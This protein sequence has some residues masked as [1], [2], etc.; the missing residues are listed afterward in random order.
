MEWSK[1]KAIFDKYKLVIIN[2]GVLIVLLIIICWYMFYNTNNIDSTNNRNIGIDDSTEIINKQNKMETKSGKTSALKNENKVSDIFVDIKGA[3][4]H[5]NI[6]KMKNIDRVKQLVDKAVLLPDADLSK[7]NLAERL[8]DQKVIY[9]PKIGEKVQENKAL[10]NNAINNI[11]SA[12]TE[13]NT[14]S[15]NL[16]K[17]NLNT[18]NESQLVLVKGIG[19]SKAKAIIE[20]REQHGA[21]ESVEQLKDVKGIGAKTLEKISSK[22]TV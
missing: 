1:L 8:Q 12:T 21:F 18:A 3:V 22:L 4:K 9:I 6:Y 11:H 10:N 19:P 7:I 20:Y 2:A 14:D 15:S 17:V 16:E 13:D 5:P